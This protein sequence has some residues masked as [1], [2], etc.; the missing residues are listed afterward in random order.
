MLMFYSGR[1]TPKGFDAEN[2]ADGLNVMMSYN[3]LLEYCDQQARFD[4]LLAERMETMGKA[5]GVVQSHFLDSGAYTQF[6]Q[7]IKYHQKN[8][9]GRWDFYDTDEFWDYIDAYAEFVKEFQPAIDFYANLDVIG[10]SELTWRN[11]KYLEEQ[12]GLNP[13]P[14]VHYT[15]HDSFSAFDRY[16]KEGYG[17]IGLGGLVGQTGYLKFHQQWL[18]TLFA[19]ISPAPKHLPTVKI[20]GFGFTSHRMLL[21]YPWW[22]VDSVSWAKLGGFGTI[23]MPMKSGKG[24]DFLRAPLKIKVSSEDIKSRMRWNCHY[25]SASDQVKRNVQEWLDFIGI[26]LGKWKNGEVVEN[27]ILT[28]HVERRAACLLYFENLVKSIPEWP[29]P[30]KP[31]PVFHRLGV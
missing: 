27:G 25:D 21:R 7:A 19:K 26:P 24:F 28:R 18:D 29:F 2:L 8:G 16:I 4:C 1:G 11:Q 14:V 13:V 12:H 22:S 30:F 3:V 20:H 15:S 17:Y 31:K 23:I 9:G 6:S 10:N 5:K